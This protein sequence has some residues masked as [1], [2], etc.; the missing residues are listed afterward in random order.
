[1][2]IL[3]RLDSLAQANPFFHLM[4]ENKMGNHDYTDEDAV[5]RD[6]LSEKGARKFTGRFV[7]LLKSIL[8]E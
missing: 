4:D 7:E 2:R 8:P 5:N 3:E 6:H 1:M